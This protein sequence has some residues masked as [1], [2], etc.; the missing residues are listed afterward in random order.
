MK[1]INIDELLFRSHSQGDLMGVN[2][3][4]ETGEKKAVETYI[5]ACTNRRKASTNSK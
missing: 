4:G 3:L 5:L 1:K 2:G